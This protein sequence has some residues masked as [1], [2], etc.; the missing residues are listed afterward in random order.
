VSLLDKT[1]SIEQLPEAELMARAGRTPLLSR[2]SGEIL[3]YAVVMRRSGAG[4]GLA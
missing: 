1:P 4:L 2:R 3:D